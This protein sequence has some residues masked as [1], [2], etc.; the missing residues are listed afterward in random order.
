MKPL[1]RHLVLYHGTDD[2]SAASILGDGID[3]N[4]CSRFTD[5]G[6]GFYTTTYLSQAKN[7]AHLKATRIKRKKPKTKGMVIEFKVN[8]T[9]LGSLNSLSFTR[10]AAEV[11]FPAA[12][13]FC[14]SGKILNSDNGKYEIVYGPV[15]QWQGIQDDK[16][17][18]MVIEGCDQ[19]S[20]HAPRIISPNDP[21]LKGAK[22]VWTD[23]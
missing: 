22:I 12:V 14:R 19:I 17:E 5:F 7:W 16:F 9:W 18:I 21:L 4:K 15:A 1:S 8:R 10:P 20:F 13:R 6:Q 23:K 11:G 2:I 3:I